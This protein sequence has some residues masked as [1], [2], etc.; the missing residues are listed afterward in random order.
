ME[1][2]CRSLARCCHCNAR[3]FSNPRCGPLYGSSGTADSLSANVAVGRQLRAWLRCT[4]IRTTAGATTTPASTLAQVRRLCG[5]RQLREP[6]LRRFTNRESCGRAPAS[7]LAQVHKHPH[8]CRSHDNASFDRDSG[9]SAPIHQARILWRVPASTLAHAQV[10]KHPHN[11]R[12]HDN[13]GYEL[14]SGE[15]ALRRSASAN[16]A[17][18]R[19]DNA[20]VRPCSCL[21]SGGLYLGRCR[22]SAAPFATPRRQRRLRSC[23]RR[24]KTCKLFSPASSFSPASVICVPPR[25]SHCRFFSPASSFSP[26]SVIFVRA[27]LSPC[28][29][30]SPP[31]PSA[32]RPLSSCRPGSAIAG[33]SVRPV[34]SAPRPLSACPFRFSHCRFFS[35][36]SS[37]SPASLSSF[38]QAQ[39]LQVLQSASSFSP[40]SVILRF[41]Q[42]QPLQVLQSASSFSPASVIF[43]PVPSAPP[44]SA[45]AGSSVP[46]VPS[47]PRPLPAC[48]Q[49]VPARPSH[50]RFF[51][52]ASSFSPASV[53]FVPPGSAI[54]GSSVRQFLQP[55]VGYLRAP[56]VQPL[57]V[58]QCG[59]FLQPRVGYLRPGQVSH[60]RFFSPASSFSPASVI[61]VQAQVQPLQVLQCRQFLQPRVGYPAPSSFSPSSV[62]TGSAI[63]GSSVRQFL[64]P[65]V[66]YLP[67][68]QI[69]CLQILQPSQIHQPSV[70]QR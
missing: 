14:G 39:P 28:R 47:A 16:L 20:L 29:F 51:S 18:E 70:G 21:K 7:S 69:Q 6:A 53:I 52:P 65:R 46:P 5:D 67:T 60:C 61:C 30:F 12:S 54:A 8:N 17:S 41:A 64:Q 57:Q 40:A 34:P 42:A 1:T 33:S 48:R 13:A 2:V 68:G 3:C 62:C 10:H 36:A 66:R 27:R 49:R 37:F 58:L 11:C 25:F 55:R 38:R 31:V 59:Q 15:A 50:C 45:I 19:R 35:P 26:A 43:V 63:A 23:R 4:N 24:N 9:G 32:P 44:S 22:S 56:Q